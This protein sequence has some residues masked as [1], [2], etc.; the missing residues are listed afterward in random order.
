M[1]LIGIHGRYGSGKD[2]AFEV[3]DQ[4]ASDRGLLAK[5][6]AFAD[7]MKV[8]GMRA[9]GFSG[10]FDD[11]F[12]GRL[13]EV[14]NRVKES[15]R[16]T[17]TWLDENGVLQGKTVTGRELWQEYGTSGHRH[18]DL[19]SSFS[20]DF[21]VNNILPFGMERGTGDDYRPKWWENFRESW[22]GFADF[23][24]VPDVR[25]VNEAQRIIDLGGEV[26]YINVEERLGLDHDG[27][28]SEKKLPSEYLSRTIDNN[29]TE[30][31]FVDNVIAAIEELHEQHVDD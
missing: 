4:W 24:V 19:G 1:K 29:T 13:F 11:D 6:R 15:G 18:P 16:I 12:D 27:H 31:D 26:W 14:A 9:L 28:L 22:A 25:F 21:W 20:D 23:A 17:T 30:I 8:S 2:T 10:W 5:R 7:A 3:I